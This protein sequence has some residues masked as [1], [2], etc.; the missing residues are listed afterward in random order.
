MKNGHNGDKITICDFITTVSNP[1]YNYK[2]VKCMNVFVGCSSREPQ[3]EVF[4][5]SCDVAKQIARWIVANN[6][7]YVFGASPNGL[8]GVIYN[9]ICKNPINS[10]IIAVTLRCW[11]D[12]LEKLKCDLS[13]TL[14]T[15]GERKNVIFKYSNIL[16]FLPGG[17]GTIDELVS[18]M[19]S[20]RSHE[21]KKEIV[22]FNPDGY[23]DGVLEAIEDTIDKGFTGELSKNFFRVADTKEELLRILNTL[24]Q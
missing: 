14:S 2:K 19:E 21:H 22:I 8:M 24:Q 16:I 15:L 3:T 20:K 17:L 7:N 1:L 9:E 10:K 6:H 18:A 11:A 5:K 13:L 12:D 4:K 23:F